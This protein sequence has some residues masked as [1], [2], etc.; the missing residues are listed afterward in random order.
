MAITTAQEIIQVRLPA[1]FSDSRLDDFVALAVLNLSEPVFGVK[2]VYAVALLAMHMYS[3]DSAGSGAG[4]V[5]S[6]KEG[7]LARS[8]GGSMT[9]KDYGTTSYGQEL[10]QLI[11]NCVWAARTSAMGT[12]GF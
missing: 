8:Y 6:E 12:L 3:K 1:L 11:N 4:G 5:K 7:D 10:L 2:Y 9:D